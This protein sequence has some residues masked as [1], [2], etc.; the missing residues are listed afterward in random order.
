VLVDSLHL[1][2]SGGIP[3]DLVGIAPRLLPYVQVADATADPVDP[4]L[5][6]LREEA[7]HGRLLPGQGALPLVEL[8]AAV[9]DVPVS[10]EMRARQLMLDYPDPLER[11]VAVLAAT[12]TLF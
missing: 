9:P 1:A 2:R 12:R 10:V 6:G 5:A 11:S 3:A 4:S 7:L 8:L